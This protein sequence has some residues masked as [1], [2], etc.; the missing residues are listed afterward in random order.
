MSVHANCPHC[1]RRFWFDPTAGATQW[2]LT[3]PAGGDRP[4]AYYPRCP[5]CG[6]TVE[7]PAPGQPR[8][9]EVPGPAPWRGRSGV[10]D[11]A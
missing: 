7:V 3:E 8:R 11:R 9:A 1:Y 6:R 2:G 4:L 10:S 5:G